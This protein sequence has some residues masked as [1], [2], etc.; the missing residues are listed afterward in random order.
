MIDDFFQSPV[1]VTEGE[2]SL[3]IT[4]FEVILRQ[5]SLK[6]ATFGSAKASKLLTRYMNFATRHGTPGGIE[7]RIIPDSS[8]S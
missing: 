8:E 7:V 2:R 5:L 6:A 1:V 4:A 3:R